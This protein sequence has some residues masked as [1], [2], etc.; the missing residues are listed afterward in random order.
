M[1]KLI[2]KEPL[3]AFQED[4]DEAIALAPNDLFPS[5]CNVDLP[6][7]AVTKRDALDHFKTPSQVVTQNGVKVPQGIT[8]WVTRKV[9]MRDIDR[10]RKE[11]DNGIGLRGCEYRA[12]DIDVAD[13]KI[14]RG[15][16]RLVERIA[17]VR[18]PCRWREDSGKRLLLYRLKY[19]KPIPKK[20][21]HIA[22]PETPVVD[23]GA[24][25]FLFD[26]QF[27][28]LF[29]THQDGARYLW[30]TP[31]SEA[32]DLEP[33]TVRRIFELI[34]KR[35]NPEDR[36]AEW[37]NTSKDVRLT[38]PRSHKDVDPNDPIVKYLFDNGIAHDMD[39]EGRV[40]VTCPF[41]HAS[42]VYTGSGSTFFPKGVG[43]RNEAGYS[44]L[45][46]TCQ[47]KG[48]GLT[49]FLYA[50]GFNEDEGEYEDL[51]KNEDLSAEEQRAVQ[52]KAELTRDKKGIIAS[53]KNLRALLIGGGQTDVSFRFDKFRQ[54]LLITH[55]GIEEPFT[56]KHYTTVRIA[57]EDN[58]YAHT[59]ST[60]AIRQVLSNAEEF[61]S[62]KDWLNGLTWDGVKRLDQFHI[63]CLKLADTP[64]HKAVIRYM[65][66]AVVGRVLEPESSKAHMVP[67]LS[68]REGLRKSTFARL[69]APL[70]GSGGLIDMSA[71]D[72]TISRLMQGKIICELDELKGI[73][74]AAA[75]SIKSL[76]T[77]D[78]DE[79]I[80][81]YK[82]S[83]TSVPRR[84]IFIGTTNEIRYLGYGDNRRW[85]P[86]SITEEIDTEYLEEN[87]DQLYAEAMVLY[88]KRQANGRSGIAHEMANRLAKPA[89]L[90]AT[91]VDAWNIPIKRFLEE[92][93]K[94]GEYGSEETP[95]LITLDVFAGSGVKPSGAPTPHD[96]RRVENLLHA[97]GYVQDNDGYWTTIV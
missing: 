45:H 66:T 3:G 46:A 57:L 15:I 1:S 86:L 17:G 79:W 51:S 62:A 91:R 89:R 36:Q 97:N 47:S 74:S 26:R 76:I 11:P 96:I 85:L 9:L 87:R 5:V 82:E 72:D 81:K 18:L 78:H 24:V 80:P 7:N 54:E 48:K 33:K 28:M 20:V 88:K 29:G 63:N 10:W 50:I 83:A 32:P 16:Q 14:A 2:N 75:E 21:M 4:W 23:A 44:C 68:S 61:D 52:V 73:D 64:Y 55:D 69:M 34:N 43:G 93:A 58:D 95:A 41:D 38:K 42:G 49:E 71:Q 13:R 27:F 8:K 77:K 31:L 65:F 90:A 25:E 12:I 30:D 37:T 59:T 94:G 92:H 19:D 35:F 40:H 70:K 53:T 56:D 84:C 6:A 67:V 22:D 60:E 39:S